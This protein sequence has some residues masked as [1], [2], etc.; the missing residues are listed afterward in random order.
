MTKANLSQWVTAVTNIAVLLGVLLLVFEL[1]QNAE[2]ARLE[3][4][5]GRIEAFQQTEAGFFTPELSQVWVKSFK[6]PESLTLAEMRMM[7]AYLAIHMAQ[8]MRNIDLE[9]AG[10]LKEGSTIALLEGDARWLFGSPFGKAYWEQFG[11][12]WSSD[13]YELANPIVDAVDDHYL[14]EE[15]SRLKETLAA[16]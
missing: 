1:R 8:M 6:D 2:L 9:K 14:I 16:D 11:P 3:M 12:N 13:L 5:Q 4:V 7:D 15:F 10:L